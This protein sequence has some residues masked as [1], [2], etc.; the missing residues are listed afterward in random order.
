[1]RIRY[2]GD[3]YDIVKQ[4]LLRWLRTF[5]EWSVHPMFTEAVLHS[6]VVAFE[7]LLDAKIISTEILTIETD[8]LAYLAC[9]SSS[10]HI[11]LDPDTG[12][13][14]RTTRGVRAPQ[15]LFAQELEALVEQRPDSLTVVF[16]QCVGRG[17]ERLHLNAKLRALREHGVFAWAYVSHACFVVA[18]RDPALLARARERVITE[19]RLPEGRILSLPPSG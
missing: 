12:L 7:S 5:G 13:R 11:F 15:F 6:D 9:C 19:S 10:G 14:M 4:S 18:G 16:D 2:L 17:S 1:M 8:R 3:S